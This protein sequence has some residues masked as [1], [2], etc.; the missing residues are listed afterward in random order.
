MKYLTPIIAIFLMIAASCSGTLPQNIHDELNSVYYWKTVFSLDSTDLAFIRKHDIKRIYLRM[1]D[2]SEDTYA[3]AIDD[4]TVPNASVRIDFLDYVLLEDSLCDKEFVPVVYVTLNALKAMKGH[5]GVLARNIV[6]RV[7]NMCEY[8]SIPNVSELQLD[9]DWTQSTEKSYFTLCDSVKLAIADLNQ[10][11][12]LSSTI[13]LHQLSGNVPPVDNGVLMVYNTGSFY[14]PDAANSIIDAND[15]E[16]YIKHLPDYPLHLDVAYPTYSW[17]LL[18]RKRHFIGL[19]NGLILTDTTH[20]SHHGGNIY[21]ARRDIPYNDRLILKGDMVRQE[22]SEFEDIY[23][24]K[25]MIDSKLSSRDHS[26]ILYHLD[27]KNLSKY[28]CDE[29]NKILSASE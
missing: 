22:T 7:R 19:M 1:F 16:P 2:V 25:R 13:R 29:I 20:F 23:K 8:N 15:V 26:N 14:D 3:S 12:R 17:Q 21:V 4:R 27:S 5:E 10:P 18:F 11:W 24:V 6:T 9:C 28:S